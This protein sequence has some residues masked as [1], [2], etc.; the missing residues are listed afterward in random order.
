[1]GAI[2]DSAESFPQPKTR[3]KMLKDLYEWALATNPETILWLYGPASAGKSA[4]MKTLAGQLRDA[5][6][7]GSCFFSSGTML[8]AA[9]GRPSS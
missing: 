8:R 1:L 9:M 7:L 4:I 5:G 3:T 6:R 2:H